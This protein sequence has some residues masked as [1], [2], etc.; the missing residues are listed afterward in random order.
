MQKPHDIHWNVAKRILQYIKGTR[1]YGI[2]YVANSKLELV[3]YIDFDWEGDSVDQKSTFIYF[4]MFVDGPI[5]W[6]S[7]KQAAIA[8][9]S[10]EAD[11]QGVV[12]A[13]I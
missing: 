10:V 4:F 6:S 11:Y 1:T 5:F 13:C 12:N 9:S 2:H 8:L 7:K 3:G